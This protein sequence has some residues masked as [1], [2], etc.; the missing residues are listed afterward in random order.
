MQ[1]LH[2]IEKSAFHKGQYVGYGAGLVWRIRR[3]PGRP[4]WK[5]YALLGWQAR[6]LGASCPSLSASRLQDMSAQLEALPIDTAGKL[7]PVNVLES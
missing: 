6:A 3:N 7:P 5:A 2:N 4:G 1:A